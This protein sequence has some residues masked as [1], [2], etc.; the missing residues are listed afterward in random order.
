MGTVTTA[1]HCDDPHVPLLEHH[2]VASNIAVMSGAGSEAEDHHHQAQRLQLEQQERVQ[3]K[4]L[5]AWINVL[6]QIQEGFRD[7]QRAE[8]L[9]GPRKYILETR[10]LYQD[11]FVELTEKRR[12]L[13][14]SL[15]AIRR[16]LG[17]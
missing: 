8:E 6:D 4:E 14:L 13:E 1:Y 16:S 10:K 17:A 11:G 15:A 12:M 5:L 3:E 7:V 9:L 2:H